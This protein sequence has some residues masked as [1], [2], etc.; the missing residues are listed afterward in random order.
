MSYTDFDSR[1]EF[2]K[3]L[4]LYHYDL[5][6]TQ[7]EFTI[8]K[9]SCSDFAFDLQEIKEN[10]NTIQTEWNNQ[11][12]THIEN[13]VAKL[14]EKQLSI[15]AGQTNDKLQAGYQIDAPQYRVKK[16]S[17]A[18]VFTSMGNLIGLEKSY[19]RYHVQFPGEVTAFHT[20]IFNPVHEF[21]PA[22]SLDEPVGKD[23][24]IRRVL[25]ALEDWDWGHVMMFGASVWT[26]W[27]AGDMVYWPYGTPHCT[28][29]MGYTPRISVSITGLATDKF[30]NFIS[31]HE[32]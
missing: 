19:A 11:S 3:S 6:K 31:S 13:T 8:I 20:D 16:C 10:I 4:N 30:Y 15:L 23:I 2:I 5:E 9:Q 24:G 29:N 27:K 7:S 14:G 25:I 22:L 17:D 28:S 1:L 18:S 26:Q 12:V 32:T 21:L